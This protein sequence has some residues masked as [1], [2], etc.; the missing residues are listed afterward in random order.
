MSTKIEDKPIAYAGA[1][2]SPRCAVSPCSLSEEAMSELA[3]KIANDV[4]EDIDCRES[5]ATLR[6]VI[7][8]WSLRSCIAH[9]EL[10]LAKTDITVGRVAL[11]YALSLIKRKRSRTASYAR[12]LGGI[13]LKANVRNEPRDE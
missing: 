5:R 13:F 12:E 4:A 8:W 7:R 9:S 11:T 6:E 10:S 3:A 1:D 2:S